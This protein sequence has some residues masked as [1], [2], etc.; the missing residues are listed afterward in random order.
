MGTMPDQI[1]VGRLDY[2]VIN[3]VEQWSTTA[4]GDLGLKHSDHGATNHHRMVVCINPHDHVQQQ[5][6]T[7]LHEILHIC[8]FVGA[9]DTA[10]TQDAVN[11]REEDFIARLT[12]WLLLVLAKNPGVVQFLQNPEG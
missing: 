7:L 2:T 8:W 4:T 10:G 3:D 11:E 1:T 12:P 9:M 5:A 6:D